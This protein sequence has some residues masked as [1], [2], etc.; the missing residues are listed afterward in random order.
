VDEISDQPLR[1]EAERSRKTK[2]PSDRHVSVRR[3]LD[4]EKKR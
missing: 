3:L 4:A 1:A 2:N